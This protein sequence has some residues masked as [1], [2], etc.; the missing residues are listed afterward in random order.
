MSKQI[1]DSEFPWCPADAKAG[2]FYKL[3]LKDLS[4]TQFAVGKAEIQMRGDEFSLVDHHH[5]ARGLHEALHEK[6]RKDLC[7]YVKVLGNGS[8]LEEPYFWKTMHQD[9]WVYLFDEN[10]GGPRAPATLPK[11]IKD[12]KFDPY[13]SLAWIVREHHGYLKNNTPFSEFKWANFFRTHILLDQDLLAGRAN[14]R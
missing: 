11:H 9:N 12:L 8:S 2:D 5:L 13:R 1:C 4:P 6:C 7:V 3:R 10:G 14:L